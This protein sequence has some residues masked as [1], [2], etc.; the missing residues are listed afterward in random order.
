MTK[1][2]LIEQL[3]LLSIDQQDPAVDHKLADKLL[4]EYINDPRVTEA[5]ESIEKWY[6]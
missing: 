4:I 1:E 2:K 6:W 5:F 3:K